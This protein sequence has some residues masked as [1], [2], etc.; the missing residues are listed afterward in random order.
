MK[1]GNAL[2]GLLAAL[3]CSTGAA[4][5]RAEDFLPDA[6]QAREAIDGLPTVRA[7]LARERMAGARGEALEKSPYGLELTVMPLARH[8]TI[9]TTYGE[10]E[11]M[12]MKRLRM[13]EKTRIDGALAANGREIAA[14]ALGDARHEGARL[15][16]ERYVAWV[17]AANAA[18][19]AEQQRTT[20]VDEQRVVERRVAAGDLPN[21]DAERARAATAAADV[22][23]ERARNEREQARLALSVAFPSLALPAEAPPIPAPTTELPPE[24]STVARIVEHSHGLGIAEAM[25]RRQA[26][27]AAR[28]DA[29]RHPDPWVG[30]RM[31]SEAR[32]TQQSVGLVL[33]IPFAASGASAT[34]R[35][36]R[37][38]GE[39]YE[40]EATGT[41]QQVTLEARQLLAALPAQI[42][43]WQAAAR[44]AELSEAAAAKV[45]RG[46][47]LGELGF[48]DLATARRTAFES[49]AAELALR[50]DVHALRARIEVDTH[51]RWE[52]D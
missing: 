47:Q 39:A 34:V 20:L 18:S 52:A 22:A 36:E 23:V 38:L 2:A 8:E 29:E 10:V 28:A 17:R 13:P 11:S 40:N 46:W 44:T 42:S 14:L 50:V 43:A 21:L 24:D 1:T 32:G 4:A 5:A 48:G 6:V 26:H 27:A 12:L 15:L 49:R 7:A 51:Q 25:A 19:L 41:A 31:L 45:L 16:L 3:I 33:T 35:A 30:L 37:A 9:G